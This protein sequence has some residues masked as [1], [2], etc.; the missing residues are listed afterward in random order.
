MLAVVAG[1]RQVVGRSIAEGSQSH[2]HNLGHRVKTAPMPTRRLTF[3]LFAAAAACGPKA[4]TPEK[5]VKIDVVID[6]PVAKK[7]TAAEVFLIECRAG[8]ETAKHM[9]PDVVA[10]VD[11]RTIDNT[12]V[13]LNKLF[14][15]VSNSL[16]LAGL[17]SEVHPD[18][19][20]QA[21]ARTCEQEGSAFTTELMLNRAV[22]DAI[23]AVPLADLDDDSQRFATVILR[24]FRRAGVDKDEATRTRLKAIDEEL[25]RLGQEFSK[26]IASDVRSI[27][28]DSAAALA[29][30]PDDFIAA[31]PT[32]TDGKIKIT[33]D[34]PDYDTICTCCSARARI[35]ATRRS[36]PT[37]WRCDPRRRRC[38]GS[39]T[40][41]TTSRKTR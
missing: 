10:A 17:Y 2:G 27:A 4:K 30:L 8:I 7:R 12:L 29:G 20:V 34:Y 39:T 5:P 14:I 6:K 18:A 21:A 31:H 13:P 22:Y 15:E 35:K 19:E 37:S 33:T 16:E 11:A 40:G 25:T 24:D 26:N 28:V 1:R 9:L 41:P 32:G 23:A 3:L 38:S 36:W